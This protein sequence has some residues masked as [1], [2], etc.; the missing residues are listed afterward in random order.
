MI[1][2]KTRTVLTARSS[3]GFDPVMDRDCGYG[4]GFM[5]HL[6]DHWFGDRCSPTAFGHSGNGG[7]TAGL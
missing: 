7:M 6:A 5:I 1:A 3:H 2:E 4:A